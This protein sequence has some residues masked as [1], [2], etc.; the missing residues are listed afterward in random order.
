MSIVS[1]DRWRKR[2]WIA[3]TRSVDSIIFPIGSVDNDKDCIYALAHIVAERQADLIIVWYPSKEERIKKY[4]DEFIKQLQ[5]VVSPDCKIQ[6]VNEDYSSVQAG[7]VLWNFNKTAAED[8]L[9]AA[10]ILEEYI[11]EVKREESTNH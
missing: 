2:L 4:I 11:K 3:Y 1:I 8:T 7:V 5:Y 9:A 10:K 6:R